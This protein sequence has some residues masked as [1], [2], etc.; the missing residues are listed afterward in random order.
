VTKLHLSGWDQATA[1]G[2]P[3]SV[4]LVTTDRSLLIAR[5]DHCK[6]C[7][8]IALRGGISKVSRRAIARGEAS[9]IEL[10]IGQRVTINHSL[11]N[12]PNPSVAR[13][14]ITL[15]GIVTRKGENPEQPTYE[16]TIDRESPDWSRGLRPVWFSPSQLIGGPS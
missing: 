4:Q 5:V 7:L 16:L 10:T 2:A 12:G 6:S 15:Q 13:I 14:P 9:P 1:C 3:S 11:S 8:R